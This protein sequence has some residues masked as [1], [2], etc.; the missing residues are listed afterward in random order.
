ME[1]VEISSLNDI[2]ED[3]KVIENVVDE[4]RLF[5]FKIDSIFED[6]E[7]LFSIILLEILGDI[8]I[9]GFFTVFFFFFID[10]EYV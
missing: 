10:I 9:E 2:I 7:I 3:Y 5:I 6:K 4:V 8:R 1:S